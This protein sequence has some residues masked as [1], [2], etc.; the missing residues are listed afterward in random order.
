M[1]KKIRQFEEEQTEFEF[2]GTTT[3]YK[4]HT[5][6]L[7]VR[8]HNWPFYSLSNNLAIVLD[9]NNQEPSACVDQDEDESGSLRWVMVN[10]DDVSLYLFI[11]LFIL[12]I[13]C[14]I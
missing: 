2:A 10:V 8:V 14:L 9:S 5:L 6:K 3:I 1:T 13:L 7:N 11:L 12:L 4:A